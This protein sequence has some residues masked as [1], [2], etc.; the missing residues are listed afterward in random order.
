M[1]KPLIEQ[2]LEK[3]GTYPVWINSEMTYLTLHPNDV[4]SAIQKA[5]EEL[6]KKVETHF[7]CQD[8]D[9]E[10]SDYGNHSADHSI[11]ET[12]FVEWLDVKKCFGEVKDVKNK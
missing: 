3:L 6:K 7:Y 4:N 11:T 12:E 10:I 9:S 1:T 8:C 2:E 5:L